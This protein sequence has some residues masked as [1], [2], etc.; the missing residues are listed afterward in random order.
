MVRHRPGPDDGD[1]TPFPRSGALVGITLG[2]G[3]ALLAVPTSPATGASASS[4]AAG[5]GHCAGQARVDVPRAEEQQLAC[6][7]DLTTTGTTVT[8]HTDPADWAGLHAAG[9]R[10]PSGIP[11][12]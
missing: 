11:G 12:V 10:N 5:R 1:M 8:G 3:A 7:D 9:T 2:L 6:L 4:V